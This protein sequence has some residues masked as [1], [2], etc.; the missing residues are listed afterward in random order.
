MDAKKRKII[1]VGATSGLGK[2][3]A[4]MFQDLGWTVGVAGRRAEKLSELVARRPDRTFSEVIDV[5]NEDA[6]DQL[7]TL[8]G[9]MNGMDVYLHCSGVGHQNRA[10]DSQIELD[11]VA[12]NASGFV[13]MV[14][15]AFQYFSSCGGGHIAVITSIAGTRGL[16]AAPA[17]SA[18]KG[19]QNI[20]IDALEQ[21]SHKE[22]RKITFTDI[23]PGFVKT[24][25]LGDKHYP[26][27]MSVDKVASRIVKAILKRQRRVIIDRR[28][29]VLVA[30]WRLLPNAVWKR[31]NAFN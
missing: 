20:Y 4:E 1:I 27:L 7:K 17:Y 19:L 22:Q 21:L 15:T 26:M 3:T 24:P 6:S 8:I 12:T 18:T 9:R 31:F 14:V 28:Y 25:L 5:N 10:L 2:A 16:G 23:R 13:R 11:T 30:L 29:A